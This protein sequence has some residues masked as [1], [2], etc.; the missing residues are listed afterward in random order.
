MNIKGTELLKILEKRKENL[1][2]WQ[3]FKHKKLDN[4]IQRLKE[5]GLTNYYWEIAEDVWRRAETFD[6]DLS[7]RNKIKTKEIQEGNECVS[8]CLN[9][10]DGAIFEIDPIEKIGQCHMCFTEFKLS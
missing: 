2:W 6:P 7:V 8:R 9:C 4:R 1:S 10:R 5:L 3:V